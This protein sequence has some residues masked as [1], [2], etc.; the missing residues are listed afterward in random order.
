M[1]NLESF[2]ELHD[3]LSVTLCTL[4]WGA[5]SHFTLTAVF[6]NGEWGKTGSLDRGPK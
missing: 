2:S 3:E 6:R 4:A 5:C 1:Y